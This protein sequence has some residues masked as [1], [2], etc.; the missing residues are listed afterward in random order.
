MEDA[1]ALSQDRSAAALELSPANAVAG[2]G[3]AGAAP[4]APV[5]PPAA[6]RGP[7]TPGATPV[8]ALTGEHVVLL[9]GILR[10]PRQM[11]R[12]E[13]RLEADGYIVHNIGY[14]STKLGLSALVEHVHAALSQPGVADA[15]AAA[16]A[17]HFIGYSLGGLITR[18]Y[19][20]RHRPPRLGRVVLLATPNHGSEVAD[21][22]RRLAPYRWIAGPVGQE[23]GTDQAAVA[24]L[25]GP[26]DY[27]CGV[28]AGDVSLDPIGNL[29]LPRPH[30]GKVSVESTR[31]AGMTDH[32]VIHAGHTFFPA[33]DRVI[34]DAVHFLREGRFA[35]A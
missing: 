12:L 10:S 5:T 8:P 21:A 19:L 15:I 2:G 35:P 6:L 28:L 16:P 11:R 13:R 32:R 31:L 1:E 34:E 20:K 29:V 9:H 18:A 23:L 25:L 4:A 24:E 26:V 3:P 7:V 22:L 17:I 33:D 27:P 14:P 30:D